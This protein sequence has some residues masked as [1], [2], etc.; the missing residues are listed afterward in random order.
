LVSITTSL[1]FLASPSSIKASSAVLTEGSRIQYKKK[2]VVLLGGGNSVETDLSE[3]KNN[4]AIQL[5]QLKALIDPVKKDKSNLIILLRAIDELSSSASTQSSENIRSSSIYDVVVP[6]PSEATQKLKEKEGTARASQPAPVLVGDFS[7]ADIQAARSPGY[8]LV[9]VGK[10]EGPYDDLEA[11]LVLGG[12]APLQLNELL[13]GNGQVPAAASASDATKRAHRKSQRKSRKSNKFVGLP[14]DG[15][16]VNDYAALTTRIPSDG[17]QPAS[18]PVG[19]GHQYDKVNASKTSGLMSVADQPAD[20]VSHLP[21]APMSSAPLGNYGMLSLVQAAPYDLA[22]HR[23]NGTEGGLNNFENQAKLNEALSGYLADYQKKL[24]AAETLRENNEDLNLTTF[25]PLLK[26]AKDNYHAYSA[27]GDTNA[28]IDALKALEILYLFQRIYQNNDKKF[29]VV[30]APPELDIKVLETIFKEQGATV[31]HYFRTLGS[32]LTKSELQKLL[33]TNQMMSPTG[34]KIC[35]ILASTFGLAAIAVM[36]WVIIKWGVQ[37]PQQPTIEPTFMPTPMLTNVP[38]TTTTATTFALQ[39]TAGPS[40]AP[41]TPTG[42]PTA[43]PTPMPT[44]LYPPCSNFYI[45]PTYS[46][47][48]AEPK[49]Y[50]SC[51]APSLQSCECGPETNP[52]VVHYEC[53]K[54]DC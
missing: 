23:F 30:V 35:K 39:P 1:L 10:K 8:E 32:G 49:Q 45:P 42:N 40:S 17:A 34:R 44:L 19:N 29:I 48:P 52:S 5:K 46:C 54:T 7:A 20:P 15:G 2:S 3:A 4:Y 38:T 31:P 22:P 28:L 50:L 43:I 16:N 36:I 14:I 37:P 47:R 6:L 41:P 13:G 27:T 24:G 51:P 53:C 11:P 21:S 25:G 9:P 26:R 33:K 12:N 18:L